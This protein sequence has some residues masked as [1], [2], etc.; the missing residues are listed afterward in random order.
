MP[1]R[2]VLGTSTE[3]GIMIM[4]DVYDYSYLQLDGQL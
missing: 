2:V 1:E 3:L 4:R